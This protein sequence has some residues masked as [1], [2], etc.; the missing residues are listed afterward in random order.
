MAG[1]QR[2]DFDTINV[3]PQSDGPWG[4]LARGISNGYQIG[5]GLIDITLPRQTTPIT[6]G[7]TN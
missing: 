4:A 2:H 3:A 7:W 5:Q 1:Y 6:K